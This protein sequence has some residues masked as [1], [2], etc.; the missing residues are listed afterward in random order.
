MPKYTTCDLFASRNTLSEAVAYSSSLIEALPQE[1]KVAAYTAL[2]VSLNTAIREINRNDIT[3]LLPRVE[4]DMPAQF[5]ISQLSPHEAQQLL[6]DS[7]PQAV[8]VS[9]WLERLA[10]IIDLPL[11]PGMAES[12]ALYVHLS[13]SAFG[14]TADEVFEEANPHVKKIKETLHV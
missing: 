12:L 13:A 3:N 1:H 2:H 8:A 10:R 4:A 9:F 5:T 14:L 7:L 6:R 11:I